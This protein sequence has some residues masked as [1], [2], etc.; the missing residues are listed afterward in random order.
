MKYVRLP[1]FLINMEMA[2]SEV[3]NIKLMAKYSNLQLLILDEWL[4]LKPS[5]KEQQDIFELLHHR[6]KKSSTILCSQ[7]R[8]EGWYES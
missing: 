7:F 2:R 5:D 1:D 6:R 8:S 3:R 4:L